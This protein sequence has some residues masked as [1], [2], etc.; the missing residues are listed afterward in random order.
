MIATLFSPDHFWSVLCPWAPRLITCVYLSGFL[1]LTYE[2]AP[3]SLD[4]P[5]RS[6]PPIWRSFSCPA[7]CSLDPA[8]VPIP[9]SLPWSRIGIIYMYENCWFSSPR[10][11]EINVP[12]TLPTFVGED[13]ALC[14]CHFDSFPDL[15]NLICFI[16]FMTWFHKWCIYFMG[17]VIYT[18][19][20]ALQI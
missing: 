10:V 20:I 5:Y 1:Y 12:M 16:L 4:V 7:S 13:L 9:G 6:D 18:G 15:W 11:T 19:F 3:L 14:G 17:I 2:S 8:P